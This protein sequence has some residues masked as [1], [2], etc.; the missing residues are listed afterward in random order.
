MALRTRV[1]AELLDMP[2]IDVVE[3]EHLLD[4]GQAESE[5]LAAQDQDQPRA[6][7]VV[8]D[9]IPADPLR[10]QQTLWPS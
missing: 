8:V 10:R 6:V 9:P 1:R 4:V 5:P 7:P 3:V 2:G